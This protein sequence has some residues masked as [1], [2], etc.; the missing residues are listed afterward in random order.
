MIDLIH[1]S[2]LALLTVLAAATT[3]ATATEITITVTGTQPKGKVL[4]Q[5]FADAAT[6]KSRS[7]AVARF[8]IEPDG[9]VF[10]T[11]INLPPGRYA[12]A[13]FQDTKGTGKLETN[14]FGAPTVPYG[15]SNNVRGSMGPPAF[16]DAAF[17]VGTAAGALSIQLR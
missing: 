13:T 3:T 4:G 11:K 9:G 16:E 12:I 6:F 14:F 5:A 15:F 2:A 1:T 10:R 8:V 7:G 17:T